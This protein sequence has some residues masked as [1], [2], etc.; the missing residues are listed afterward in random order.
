MIAVAGGKAK[1]LVSICIELMMENIP[2]IDDKKERKRYLKIVISIS[3]DDKTVITRAEMLI[4]VVEAEE[5][6]AAATKPLEKDKSSLLSFIG[7]HQKDIA[8]RFQNK[9]KDKT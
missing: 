3:T 1:V 8:E 9:E 6:E 7:R 5:K 4:R 2:G